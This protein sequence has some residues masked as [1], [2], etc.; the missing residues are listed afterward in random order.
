MG[1]F[2]VASLDAVTICTHHWSL[3]GLT[4][5]HKKGSS[6]KIC[7]RNTKKISPIY[8]TNS[9]SKNDQFGRMKPVMDGGFWPQN[10]WQV[11]VHMTMSTCL[12][13]RNQGA[14]CSLYNKAWSLVLLKS[15]WTIFS[16]AH[17]NT[18]TYEES[19]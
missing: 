5:Q 19:L 11:E 8:H 6:L 9:T 17:L 3:N 7:A 13:R 10:V 15:P 14:N 16:R 4:L 18:K 12:T 1:D 2:E